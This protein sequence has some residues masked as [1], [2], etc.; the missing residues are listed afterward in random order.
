MNHPLMTARQPIIYPESDGLPM[1][2]NSRQFR[3]ILVLFGNTAAMYR[4]V[5]DVWVWGDMFWYPVEG[6]PEINNAPDVFV[7][8]GRPK[9]ERGFYRQWEEDNVPLTVVFEILS[10]AN[11]VFQMAD[12]LAFYDEYGVE[13]Y[14]IYDPETNQLMVYLR[15]GQVLRRQAPGNSFVSPRLGIRFD[16]S[17]AEMVVYRPDGQRFLTFEELEAARQQAQQE[18]AQAQQQAAQAQQQAA[19]A[20]QQAAQAQQRA[21]RLAELARKLRQQRV[22]PEELAELERLEN[23]SL[24]G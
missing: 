14:Y 8:F 10:P 20:Q 21:A 12:K 3:W 19:Q 6:H 7:V 13:E 2:D 24:P 17:G 9:G 18:A 1:A 23:E 15:R 16:L 11:T 5:A 4:D 22:S